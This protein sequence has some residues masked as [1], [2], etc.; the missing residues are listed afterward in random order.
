LDKGGGDRVY[1]IN[2]DRKK[3]KIGGPWFEK[4]IT[5]FLRLQFESISRP[6]PN[7]LFNSKKFFNSYQLFRV[8]L[9][10]ANHA[11]NITD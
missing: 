8:I 10:Y 3:F 9:K 2:Y 6:M 4:E 11:A 5:E 7:C 1:G